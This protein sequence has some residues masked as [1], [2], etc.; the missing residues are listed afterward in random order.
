M[1]AIEAAVKPGRVRFIAESSLSLLS[2]PHLKRLKRNGFVS[3]LP[4]IESW[5]DLG[6][7]S[8]TGAASGIEKVRQV[9]D[10]VNLI[11]SY[12]PHIQTNFVLGLDSD[13]GDEPFELTKRFID[14]APGAYPAFSLLTCL[15]VERRRAACAVACAAWALIDTLFEF[16]Q[17]AALAAPLGRVLQRWSGWPGAEAT[18]SYFLRGRFDPFDVLAAWAGAVA[19]LLFAVV[20]IARETRS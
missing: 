11:Q 6:N 20:V 16:G 15:V 8:K 9:A 12:I 5:Y 17:H 1:A 18:A 3:V 13:Q 7:K 4:G 19:A 10:H 2:E 14:L